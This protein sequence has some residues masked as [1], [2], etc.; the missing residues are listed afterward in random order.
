ME[1]GSNNDENKEQNKP[2]KRDLARKN[3]S[4]RESIDAM[5]DRL[6]SRGKPQESIGRSALSNTARPA[7]KTWDKPEEEAQGQIPDPIPQKEA[8]KIVSQIKKTLHNDF[9]RPPPPEKETHK[10]STPPVGAPISDNVMKKQKPKQTYRVKLVIV[11]LAFFVIAMVISS[12]SLYFGG[13]SIS[14]ENISIDIS[15]T[16]FTIGGGEQLSFQVAIANQNSVPI[17]SATLI[18]DYP[19]GTQSAENSGEEL[20]SERVQLND[21]DT[22]EVINVPL[23]A[24]IFGEE[25][26]EKTINASVEYR[27][28]GSNAIFFKEAEPLR[29]KI[30]SSPVTIRVN[31]VD[32]ISS[33]QEIEIGLIIRSNSPTPL[34][35]I[36]VKASY[37]T[38]F[39]FTESDTE[40]SSGQDTWLIED[41]APEEEQ[42]I[43]IRGLIVGKQNEERI[44]EFSVGVPNERDRFGLASVFS[45]A[46]AEVAMEEPFLDIGV[47]IDGDSSET[48]VIS[49]KDSTSV[50]ITFTNTQGDAIYDGVITAKLSG[51]ALNEIEIDVSDGFYDSTTNI[52]TW[53][54]VDV[55]GLA[56]IAPGQSNLVR[57][58]LSPEENISRTPEIGLEVTVSGQRVYDDR[59]PQELVGSISR[60][61]RV[62]SLTKLESSAVY[63]VGQF[64]NTGPIPPIA[65]EITQYTFNMEVQNGSNN[66]TNTEV[67]AVLPPD[68]ASFGFDNVIRP[69]NRTS[70]LERAR[71][72]WA[73]AGATAS[74]VI[75]LTTGPRASKR[76]MS[77][78]V[79]L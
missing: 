50:N 49:T 4:E 72:G 14:G 54:S 75:S 44:F 63:S 42:T 51:N 19:V 62:E 73:P 15:D 8:P 24:I 58:R 59:V 29:L 6:Y 67:T 35:D 74:V 71:Q 78:Q 66:I 45:K 52:I 22:G 16:Q 43:V 36:L 69:A 60:T 10:T 70:R 13:G 39:D 28:R 20:F 64:T 17:E 21:I 11:G 47:E 65:E 32:S 12:A 1:K 3:L 18:I 9:F 27:V 5:R 79:K 31:A 7:P 33:G 57:F 23:K 38:G 25:N 37:P 56:E 68:D 55:E 40:T 48:V 41:L 26:E 53:D 2:D 61:I 34:S 30:N 46:T 76:R 77:S